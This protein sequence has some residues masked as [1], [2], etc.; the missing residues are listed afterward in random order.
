MNSNDVPLSTLVAIQT[1]RH[2][3]VPCQIIANECHHIERERY[4]YIYLYVWKE[5]ILKA[6]PVDKFSRFFEQWKAAFVNASKWFDM[7][8]CFQ[9][10]DWRNHKFLIISGTTQY[11]IATTFNF[12]P[13]KQH[14][15]EALSRTL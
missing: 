4:I 7:Y 9:E 14:L 15:I 8:P 12:K 11:N 10:E 13:L 3:A 2:V 6:M 5:M 1:Q